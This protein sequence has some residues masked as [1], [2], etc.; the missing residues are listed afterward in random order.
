M[1]PFSLFMA[2]EYEKAVKLLTSSDTIGQTVWNWEV[3]I[4][5]LD[6]EQLSNN[7]TYAWSSIYS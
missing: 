1:P 5:A 7:L 2:H 4:G 6:K 3:F